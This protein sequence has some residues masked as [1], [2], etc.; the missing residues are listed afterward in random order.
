MPKTYNDIY[1]VVRNKLRESG[2]E[3]YGLE[4]RTLL[5]AAAGKTTEQLLRDMYL[6]TSSEIETRTEEMLERRLK[7]E[8]LAYIAGSW[9][10]YG[11]PFTVTPDVLIPRIDTEVLV[12]CVVR[13]IRAFGMKGRVLDLCCGSGCI[14]CAVASELPAA[15]V[16]AADISLPALDIARKN[17]KDN[18]LASRIITIHADAKTWPPMSIGSFDVI[19]SN[20]PYIASEEILTLDSSVR[21][22]EPLGALDGGTDGLDFYRAIIK[23]WTIT[24]RPNGMMMFEVGEGQA[25]AVKKM[26][27]GA[28]Y[29]AVQ[30]VKD[31]L[32]VERVVIG[33][34]KNE[35]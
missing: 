29:V 33:K 23:Y 25:D 30:T 15:R 18:K 2:V 21:D 13:A 26:L 7:G 27:L 16:V 5:A 24:L 14:A 35:F 11:L 31:T 20:P 9:E 3:A 22:H 10:F 6:Y 8:P 34:W 28:G 1:F 12:A 32:G 19:A 4:A 17:I